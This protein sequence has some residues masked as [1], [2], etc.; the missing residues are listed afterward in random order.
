ME[1]FGLAV[2]T[3][4]ASKVYHGFSYDNEGRIIGMKKRWLGWIIALLLLSMM[5]IALASNEE[6]VG[7]A[8]VVFFNQTCSSY[9]FIDDQFINVLDCNRYHATNIAPGR[10]GIWYYTDGKAKFV[11]TFEF[12]PGRNY[13]IA[14]T[15]EGRHSLLSESDAQKIMRDMNEAPLLE[16]KNSAWK[17]ADA[18]LKK[19]Y[20]EMA[21][22]AGMAL[23]NMDVAAYPEATEGYFKIPK[24]TEIKLAFI[25]NM[26]SAYSKEGDPV[27]FQATE[28][29][30]VGGQVFIPKNAV[31]QG[32]VLKN[33]PP[34]KFGAPAML[35]IV[36]SNIQM[37]DNRT[38][39]IIGRFII[40]G[41]SRAGEAGDIIRSGG[42]SGGLLGA[43]IASGFAANV[44]GTNAYVFCGEKFSAWT[45]ENVFVDPRLP[46]KNAA[47]I[48][49]DDGRFERIKSQIP[50]NVIYP[51]I[52]A[53]ANID[54]EKAYEVLY[55]SMEK[56][57]IGAPLST[58]MR[59]QLM[60]SLFPNLKA[61][62]I[63]PLIC[64]KETKGYYLKI[65][66]DVNA[67]LMGR[68]VFELLDP[69]NLQLIVR[70]ESST[71]FAMSTEGSMNGLIKKGC[72][73]LFEKLKT[74]QPE[75][76]GR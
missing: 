7:T 32:Y 70:V 18:A 4:V 6:Q 49:K 74:I 20:P 11:N 2:V 52:K 28:D 38:I 12:I 29:S 68:G 57:G 39:P 3:E 23:P 13:Y 16:M 66:L 26:S 60:E 14:L 62:D 19:N 50:P 40:A 31:I 56:P 55:A 33:L 48:P 46:F 37:A 47:D 35:D 44:K 71:M 27:L 58:E 1:G 41:G 34:D 61:D 24:Y 73:A 15:Q 9:L 42:V 22:E 64:A 8:R 54:T 43:L 65:R 67:D 53:S 69:E 21:A 36:I 63:P 10:H 25:K 72:A 45:R 76:I 51:M 17:K 75:L 5:N 30:V 59:G